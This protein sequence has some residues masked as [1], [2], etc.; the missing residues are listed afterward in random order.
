MPA[1]VSATNQALRDRGYAVRSVHATEDSGSVQGEPRDAGPLEAVVV[2][3]S[4]SA[5]GT[6]VAVRVKPFGDEAQSRAIL[7][8]ILNRLG[9]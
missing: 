6:R 4:L 2:D 1:V 9:L 3:V 8:A 7:D 5:D